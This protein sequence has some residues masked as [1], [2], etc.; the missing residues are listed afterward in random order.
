MRMLQKSELQ[1][2]IV[3]ISSDQ[4]AWSPSPA[5]Q[6]ITWLVQRR[7][8]VVEVNPDRNEDPE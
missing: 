2:M 8:G 5:Y 6:D 7:S 1:V 3:T 4:A